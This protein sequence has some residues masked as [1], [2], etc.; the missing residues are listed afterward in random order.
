MN[1]T[2]EAY[3]EAQRKYAEQNVDTEKTLKILSESPISIHC[4]QTDDVTGFEKNITKG[5][6]ILATGNYHGKARNISEVM[7]D[8]EE[9]L[10]LTPG[11][12][13]INLHAIYGK[14]DDE[15]DRDTIQPEQFNDWIEWA[16][17][18]GVELDFNATL[19]AHPKAAKGFTLSARA[20]KA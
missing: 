3:H 8:L 6:G 7:K 11:A 10:S 16:K 4:W 1:N 15:T 17:R 13:R 19:F 5:G 14:F 12:K 20:E 2:N 18:V 9:V